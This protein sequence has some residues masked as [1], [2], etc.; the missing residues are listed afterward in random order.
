MHQVAVFGGFDDP[1]QGV[2]HGVIFTDVRLQSFH[3]RRQPDGEGGVKS[4]KRLGA[5]A[6]GPGLLQHAFS[7][8]M[9]CSVLCEKGGCDGSCNGLELLHLSGMFHLLQ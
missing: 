4:A 6:A 5:D 7:V 2:D 1:Q 9:F 8:G 3:E